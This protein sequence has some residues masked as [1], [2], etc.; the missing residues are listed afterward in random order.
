MMMPG[1]LPT[2][3]MKPGDAKDGGLPQQTPGVVSAYD[4]YNHM[5]FHQQMAQ[6]Y[7]AIFTQQMA[8][9]QQMLSN[10]GGNADQTA[11]SAQQFMQQ[12]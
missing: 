11:A 9:Q 10:Q 7:Q 1:M 3:P 12:Q 6:H 4:A 2:N 8:L 5:L